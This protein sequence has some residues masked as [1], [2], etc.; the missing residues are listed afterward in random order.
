[1]SATISLTP[2]G[3]E[4]LQEQLARG[5]CRSPEEVVETA[6]ETLAERQAVTGPADRPATTPAEAVRTFWRFKRVTGWTA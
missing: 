6:L 4:L 3:E 1:M 5:T 2:H